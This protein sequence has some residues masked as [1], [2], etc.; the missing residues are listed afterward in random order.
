MWCSAGHGAGL[1]MAGD[2]PTMDPCLFVRPVDSQKGSAARKEAQP[3]NERHHLEE[4]SFRVGCVKNHELGLN[5]TEIETLVRSGTL[6]CPKC[7][8]DL[9]LRESSIEIVCCVCQESME[10]ASL[11]EAGLLVNDFCGACANNGVEHCT[12]HVSDSLQCHQDE[13]EWMRSGRD[14]SR[15]TRKNRPDYWEGAVHFCS[16]EQ[17]SSIYRDRRIRASRTGYFEVPAVCLT[18]APANGWKELREIHGQFGFVFRKSDLIRAGGGP[19]LYLSEE[20]IKAQ[21][22]HVGLKAL[23]NLLRIPSASGGK[24]AWDYLHEREWRMP[25][26]IEFDAL[27]PYAVVRGPFNEATPGWRDIYGALQEFEELETGD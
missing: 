9:E 16:A 11:E 21:A 7:G 26:D 18:E 19:V 20:R 8:R 4:V 6:D 14:P 23:V 22:W 15:L 10:A 24:R 3:M 27:K 13:Y 12:L 17:F 5:A 1:G 25:I 2:L